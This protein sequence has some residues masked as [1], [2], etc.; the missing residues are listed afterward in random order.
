MLL[1][2][3]LYSG[4]GYDQKVPAPTGSGSATLLRGEVEGGDC[5]MCMDETWVW[6]KTGLPPVYLYTT[7]AWRGGIVARW[8]IDPARLIRQYT[9]STR[10][11]SW[12]RNACKQWSKMISCRI[13]AGVGL[14]YKWWRRWKCSSSELWL[15]GLG[16]LLWQS[17]EILVKFSYI[18]TIYAH[19]RGKSR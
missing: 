11:M 19:I 7:H 10:V 2:S 15:Y 4:S 9:Q 6:P 18:S 5:A 13:P 8:R 12:H 1:P 14:F 17:R 3:H 16:V